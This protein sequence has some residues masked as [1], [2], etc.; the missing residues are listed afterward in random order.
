VALLV[1]WLDSLGTWL[2]EHLWPLSIELAILTVVVAAIVYGLRIKAPA[3]RHLFWT[4]VLVKPAV[5]L[6]VA[7]PV[8]LY[9][10]LQPRPP[11]ATP[12]QSAGMSTAPPA[13]WRERPNWWMRRPVF[14]S[15]ES[16]GELRETPRLTRGGV[17]G[18]AWLCVA[19][20]LALRIAAGAVY[21]AYLRRTAE[22]GSHW[23]TE[24][25]AE[26]AGRLGVRRG[27][28]VAV[29]D[30]ADGPVLAG[31]IRPTVILPKQLAG[32][33]YPDQLRLVL[34]HEVAHVRRHDNLVLLVQRV[35]EAFVFFHPAI[36]L[37]GWMLR[38]EAEAACDDAVVGAF[39]A[40]E[41]YA[42]SL[43][44]VAEMRAG[45]TRLLLNAF[46]SGESHMAR[47]VR[48][49][50]GGG[51]GRMT[52]QAKVI[53]TLLLLAVAL[54]ALPSAASRTGQGRA[55]ELPAPAASSTALVLNGRPIDLGEP[56]L[57][58]GP[59]TL[60]DDAQVLVPVRAVFQK[61]GYLVEWRGGKDEY[62][63]VDGYWRVQPMPPGGGYLLVNTGEV[64]VFEY[65][66]V[67]PVRAQRRGGRL[68]APM[69]LIRILT[70][71]TV[72]W[73]DAVGALTCT[74]HWQDDPPL[75]AI[76]RILDDLATWE[77]RRVRIRARFV[78]GS[79]WPSRGTAGDDLPAPAAWLVRDD[80]GQMYCTRIEMITVMFADVPNYEP[81]QLLDIQGTVRTG[82]GN[83]PYLSNVQH[84]AVQGED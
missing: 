54:A 80:S 36:W 47:R 11:E 46:A 16:G 44:R 33:L 70:G 12:P 6:L 28:R 27:I 75:L 84:A 10:F 55:S 69:S 17:V 41:Q 42:D 35:V 49:I 39:G 13:A 50:L 3:I 32:E 15:G 60:G 1:T 2:T 67:L 83:V 31:I 68:Y 63:S 37:C 74:T 25:L 40:A 45:L 5:T 73:D 26:V 66:T 24:A 51:G 8:S 62:V 21:V 58:F 65:Q 18:L 81:G 19:V 77:H 48:R 7:S 9:W 34:A 61:L 38:R 82:K 78:Q 71:S 59:G 57:Y 64:E 43:T 79:A 56:V 4:L 20:M 14:A 72:A 76:S 52:A 30:L 23:L 29:S 22:T 53:F